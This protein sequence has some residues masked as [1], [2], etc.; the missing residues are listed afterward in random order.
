[1]KTFVKNFLLSVSSPEDSEPNEVEC[2]IAEIEK[3][4]HK[5]HY[6]WNRFDYAAPEYVELAVLE[7]LLAETHYSLLN[8]RYR[9]MLGI[10]KPSFSSNKHLQNLASSG[11][12]ITPSH[13]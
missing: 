4:R 13:H 6:A 9:M 5:I 11:A 8:K 12:L 1:M 7:L 3:A 2:L 10:S